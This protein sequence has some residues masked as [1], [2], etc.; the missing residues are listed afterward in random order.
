MIVRFEPPFGW[1]NP[2]LTGEPNAPRFALAQNCSQACESSQLAPRAFAHATPSMI[3]AVL[4][5]ATL[6]RD[7][8]RI[9]Y[10]H[11]AVPLRQ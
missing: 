7:G 9:D 8:R 1:N 10:S 6:S 11:T 4:G 3:F 5:E 2:K